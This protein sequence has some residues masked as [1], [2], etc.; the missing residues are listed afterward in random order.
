MSRGGIR[1]H[2]IAG[3]GS[4]AAAT[5]RDSEGAVSETPRAR[6]STIFSNMDRGEGRVMDMG[7]IIKNGIAGPGAGSNTAATIRDSEGA[8]S[9]APRARGSTI[10][11]A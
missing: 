3:A 8:D 4:N 2:G 10:F 6:G 5:I 9:E 7:G 1:E 11:R